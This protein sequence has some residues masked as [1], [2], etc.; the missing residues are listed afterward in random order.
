MMTQP[1]G[2]GELLSLLARREPQDDFVRLN[3]YRGDVWVRR[4]EIMVID[5]DIFVRQF[6]PDNKGGGFVALKA[7]VPE[8]VEIYWEWFVHPRTYV[9]DNAQ[10]HLGNAG[11]HI[12]GSTHGISRTMRPSEFDQATA[13]AIE[14]IGKLLDGCRGSWSHVT[15]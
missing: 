6:T 13:Q 15:M 2:I 10:L 4:G 3:S 9:F 12:K 1:H 7:R 11:P 5:G 14:R 8:H